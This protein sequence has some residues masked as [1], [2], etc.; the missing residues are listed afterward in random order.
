MMSVIVK[1]L[2]DGK[3]FV[4]TK[5]ADDKLAPLSKDSN[6][7]KG[8][9]DQVNKFAQEGYRTLMFAMREIK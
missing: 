8:V 4:F 2:S 3:I 1:R 6:A 5:G 9:E 7:A